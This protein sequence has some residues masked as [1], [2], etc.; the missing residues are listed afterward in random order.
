[1]STGQRGGTIRQRPSS[2]RE[3][4]VKM[5]LD[6]D[7]ARCPDCPLREL[8]ESELRWLVKIATVQKRNTGTSVQR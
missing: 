5:G 3:A 6:R 1:M 7:G 8:C 2:L 4:C